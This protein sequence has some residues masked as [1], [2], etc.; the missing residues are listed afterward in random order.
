MPKCYIFAHQIITIDILTLKDLFKLVYL[1]VTSFPITLN[2][3]YVMI[4]IFA[5][6]AVTLPSLRNV[7][8]LFLL[9]PY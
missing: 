3:K 5:E 9:T 2:Y 7:F 4:S 8:V 6:S 1:R